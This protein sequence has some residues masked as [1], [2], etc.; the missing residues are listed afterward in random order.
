MNEKNCLII[1]DIQHD[2]FKSGGFSIDNS[3][4]IITP[5]NNL[6][7]LNWDLIVLTQ[8]WHPKNHISFASTHNLKPFTKLKLENGFEMEL[9]P[10]HCVEN[11]EGS[12]FEKDLIVKSTDI[13]IKK[14]NNPKLDSFSAFIDNSKTEKTELDNILKKKKIKKIYVCGLATD[15]CVSSTALDAVD[16]GYEVFFIQDCS[17][18][19][20]EKNTNESLNLMKKKNIKFINSNQIN[21]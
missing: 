20:F 10:N 5:I 21:L 8:D 18:G 2:G 3:E 4:D 12:E 19:M 15:Y 1:V 13:I 9:W 6:R 7:K 16:L 11:T 17:K 14:G